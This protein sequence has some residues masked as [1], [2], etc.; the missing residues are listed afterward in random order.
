M[1][2]AVKPGESLKYHV[3]HD[4]VA[5]ESVLGQILSLIR[6]GARVLELGCATGSMTR[7]LQSRHGCCVDAV[8]LDAVAAEVARPYCERLLVE[9][10]ETVAWDA[11]FFAG[12]TYD[13]VLIADVL[14]H[15]RDPGRVLR[16]VR[17]LLRKGG[18]IVVSTP[19]IGFA[20][21][22]A[23]LQIGWFPYG[24]TGLL[25]RGHVHFFTRFELEALML[26][27]GVVPV[28]RR[29]VH[30]GPG[31]SEFGRYWR[32]LT[33]QD[34]EHLLA[35]TDAAVYQ[36]VVA[37]EL[38]SDDAWRRCVLFGGNDERRERQFARL[39]EQ[40]S[41]MQA[42][43]DDAERRLCAAL[44]RA[45]A[46]ACR[47]RELERELQTLREQ[48]DRAHTDLQRILSSRSWRITAPMRRGRQVASAMR[49]NGLRLLASIRSRGL[50]LTLRRVAQRMMGHPLLPVPPQG[51][52]AS[53]LLTGDWGA[54][55]AWLTA[56]EALPTDG[57]ERAAQM[58]RQPGPWPS[59]GVVVP[60]FNPRLDWLD[61]AIES[62]RRQW[63][64]HWQLYLVDDCSTHQRVELTA[65]L[66]RWRKDDARIH[67]V[68]RESNGHISAATNDGVALSGDE[69]ITFLDQDDLLPPHAL[70]CVATAIRQRPHARI[71]Y[72]DEDKIDAQGQRCEPHFKPDWNP[73]LLLSYNY[74]CHLVAYR[75]ED[76]VAV[77]GLR[78]GFEGAQDYDL[79]LRVVERCAPH[80][81]VHI[82]RVLYHWRV[83]DRSTARDVGAKPYALE[84]G[85]RAL[86]EAMQRRRVSATVTIEQ[87]RAYRVRYRIE[88]PQPHV[89]MVVPTRNGGR[90][91]QTCIDSVIGRTDY[92]PYD[93]VII[94]NGS[95][96]PQTLRLLQDYARHPLCTVVRDPRPFNYAALHNAIVPSVQGEYVVLLNDDIEVKDADWLREM[97]SVA[98]QPG[99]GIVGA[100]LLYPN[101][102]LQ[103]GG[104]LLVG[105]VAGHAHKRL[106]A[107]H[108][109]YM[110]RARVRQTL[111]AVTAACL[112]VPKAVYQQVGG[113]D[114]QL[115]V[116]FN[117]VA[118]C[119][120]VGEAGYRIVWTPY[121]E[122]Y[123]HES[124]TRGYEHEDPVK[125][126]RFEGEVRYMQERWGE[127]LREDP[128]LNPNLDNMREDFALARPPRLPAIFD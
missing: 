83:H 45:H 125:Q 25:D 35:A 127:R 53:E 104:V 111:S 124:A 95:D 121:A 84:A 71:V 72:S 90:L 93:I 10:L 17:R 123:H 86:Q 56:Y 85:R 113:M 21:L 22:Q 9:D 107:D 120:A 87:N 52:T 49:V 62:V 18:S 60:V 88:G 23:A 39:S 4:N 94:D 126:R 19:N 117:D 63:Y 97:V 61:A 112:L 110:M 34:R 12:Q 128:A 15:L 102:T 122:L 46:D 8:E 65:R 100:R 91:L 76:V 78:S 59:I 69:W 37:A 109:G 38:P 27:C 44:E 24:P 11:P 64:P 29:A 116:A 73:D 108:W 68:W 16:G 26:S 47:L 7:I 106:P 28:E 30:W 58:L 2:A 5:P 79:A 43:L 20:G 96:Q 67:V 32:Q 3:D 118:F 75:R 48:R 31:D 36:W 54:Y 99:V 33:P 114:E 81:I 101:N 51:G 105:G 1:T 98:L 103:H 42:A 55:R 82:P 70:W 50:R 14:E 41:S 80:Q 77:G 119:L 13:H 115:A 66:E 57:G 89:T 92:A 74:L 40:V 6:P